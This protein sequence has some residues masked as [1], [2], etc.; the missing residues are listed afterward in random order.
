MT[1]PNSLCLPGL[2]VLSILALP[3][4]RA[5]ESSD[6]NA[7]KHALRYKFKAGETLRWEVV[8]RALVKTTI[9]GFTDTTEMVSK[10][11]K[12]W[13]VK[14]VKDDGTAVF[15]NMVESLDMRQKRAGRQEIRYNSETDK[16]PPPEFQM[17]PE[18]IGVRLSTITMSPSGNVVDRKK[19]KIRA[20]AQNEQGEITVPFPKGPIAAGKS[21]SF[22]HDIT[23]PLN[24]G[25]IKTVKSEQKFTLEGVKTGIA[26]IRVATVILTPISNPV[27]EAQLI[28][29]LSSGTVR[30]DIEAGRV[31]GQQMDLDKRVIGFVGNQNPTSSI[32]YLT[33][34][35]EEF[36]SSETASTDEKTADP[37]SKT[38]ESE[39][40]AK[41][42]EK[43]SVAV[44]PDISEVKK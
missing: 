14:E 39:S 19:E 31:I 27:I 20:A 35:T 40:V 12:V 28:Q 43:Q 41:P 22:P 34:F 11:I 25:T 2:L 32:H 44:K 5:E 4:A 33:R 42:G 30:F 37:E 15:E 10:S 36:L 3:L 38:A 7:P 17:V 23:V 24:N 9:S 29:R 18:S 21:W 1:R 16:E 13:R 6:E 8:Q 26:T